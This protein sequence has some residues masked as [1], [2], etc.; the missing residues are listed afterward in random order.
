[1]THIA[2]TV[3]G[4]EWLLEQESWLAVACSQHQ[5]HEAED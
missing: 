2:F 5:D 1:M 3:S 4:L